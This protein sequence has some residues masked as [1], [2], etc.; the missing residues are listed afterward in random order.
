MKD[1]V[2]ELISLSYTGQT[3]K[4]FSLVFCGVCRQDLVAPWDD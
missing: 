3:V 1:S 2:L 4:V